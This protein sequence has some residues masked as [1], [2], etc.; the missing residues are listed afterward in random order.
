M[1]RS[2]ARRVHMLPRERV[3]LMRPRPRFAIAQRLAP[4]LQIDPLARDEGYDD[5]VKGLVF[6]PQ[7]LEPISYAAGY[8]AGIRAR[9]PE[10][11]T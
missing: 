7:D 10:G 9:V 5:G 11:R 3:N 6:D 1:T 2:N 4:G 8:L